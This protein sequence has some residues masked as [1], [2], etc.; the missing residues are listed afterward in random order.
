MLGM[1]L[2][3]HV[4]KTVDDIILFAKL[5]PFLSSRGSASKDREMLLILC[6]LREES[7]TIDDTSYELKK[8]MIQ[9]LIQ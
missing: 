5:Q 3:R 1:S 6:E 2:C 4:H 7:D 8:A 9:N